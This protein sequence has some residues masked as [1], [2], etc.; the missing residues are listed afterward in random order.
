M[1]NHGSEQAADVGPRLRSSVRLPWLCTVLTLL[2]LA[3]AAFA[4]LDRTVSTSA[5]PSAVLGSQEHLTSEYAQLLAEQLTQDGQYAAEVAG[6]LDASPDLNQASYFSGLSGRTHPW[7]VAPGFD[8]STLSGPYVYTRH[9]GPDRTVVRTESGTQ[10]AVF[11]DGARTVCFTG[12]SRTFAEPTSTTS[13]ITLDSWVRLAPKRWSEGAQDGSWFHSWFQDQVGSGEP[14]LFGVYSQYSAG[15]PDKVNSQGVRYAGAAKFGVLTSAEGYQ[16][17][18]GD[19]DDRADFYDYLGVE[20]DFP[21]G[22]GKP[23]SVWY[24]DL[25][26]SGLV[27]I[28]YGYRMGY[29]MLL[30]D[31][32]SSNTDTLPRHS[33]SIA[34]NGPGPWLF[35]QGATTRPTSAD[36]AML[37]AGDLLFFAEGSDKGEVDHC[38]IYF[39]ADQYGRARFISCRMGS[40]G[41]TFGDDLGMSVVGAGTGIYSVDFRGARRI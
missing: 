28:L 37:Q 3:G 35:G 14:D 34:A 4:A 12:P 16:N 13:T 29:P 18:L 6:Q 40:N 11:T 1:K 30:G 17:P 26:C 8:K 10:V 20:Y 25:D 32:S 31:G 33:W 22:T 21:D 36:L 19:R 27:R 9:T 24:G 2:L 5:V 38:G 41:P 7:A 39:G 23:H 15:A